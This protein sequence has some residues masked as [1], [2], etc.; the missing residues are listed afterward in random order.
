[1]SLCTCV[2]L[3]T[4]LSGSPMTHGGGLSQGWPDV[5]PVLCGSF[6]QVEKPELCCLKA[7]FLFLLSFQPDRYAAPVKPPQRPHAGELCAD[8]VKCG[9]RKI[10]SPSRHNFFSQPLDGQRPCWLECPH[11]GCSLHWVLGAHGGCQARHLGKV[12]GGS[13]QRGPDGGSS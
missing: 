1:M 8:R 9:L 2:S 13:K 5:Q 6:R 7:F 3:H 10:H 4:H 11:G 12:M